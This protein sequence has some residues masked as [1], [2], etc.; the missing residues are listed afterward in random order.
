[1]R[2]KSGALGTLTFSGATREPVNTF[3]DVI[4]YGEKG[5]IYLTTPYTGILS[6]GLVRLN[7]LDKESEVYYSKALDCGYYEEF[8]NFWEAVTQGQPVLGTPFEALK[9]WELTMKLLES[10]QPGQ[11]VRFD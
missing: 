4:I 8:L 5:T 1:L 9:D 11:A 7:E 2:F 10:A 3:C 6:N